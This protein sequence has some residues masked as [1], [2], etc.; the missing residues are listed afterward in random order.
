MFCQRRK[1]VKYCCKL[2]ARGPRISAY[3]ELTTTWS[4]SRTRVKN[5]FPVPLQAEPHL[6]LSRKWQN[7]HW[8]T[9]IKLREVL[10]QSAPPYQTKRKMWERER[11][12]SVGKG[13]NGVQR[14]ITIAV[15]LLPVQNCA[16]GS[17]LPAYCVK[18][19]FRVQ[20][21]INDQYSLIHNK[22]AAFH[23]T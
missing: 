5:T 2:D 22:N 10:T 18:R 14:C 8:L 1:H 21:V 6:H 16:T 4:L 13:E 7:K 9:S 11:M 15:Q 3:K 20:S 17:P 12:G 23:R 19:V